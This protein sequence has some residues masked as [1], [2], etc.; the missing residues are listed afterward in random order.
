L[1]GGGIATVSAAALLDTAI[2]PADAASTLPHR[3]LAESIAPITN[4]ATG[5]GLFMRFLL[6]PSTNRHAKHL[7]RWRINRTD[8]TPANVLPPGAAEFVSDSS[9]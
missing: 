1:A 4:V 6:V 2:W 8:K 3:T 9:V 7:R 5:A